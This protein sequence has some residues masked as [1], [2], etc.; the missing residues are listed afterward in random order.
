MSIDPK[1]VERWRRAKGRRE[2][3]RIYYDEIRPSL[4]G[5]LRRQLHL[6]RE[7]GE[8]GDYDTLVL[9]VGHDAVPGLILANA[10]RPRR[11]VVAYT[12]RNAGQ[13]QDLFLPGLDSMVREKVVIEFLE[14]GSN[15]HD[16]NYHKITSMLGDLAG[17][18]TVLCDVTGGKK[19]TSAHLGIAAERFGFD[20]SYID[21]TEYVENSA[22][23]EPG[24]EVLYIHSPGRRGVVEIE[25]WPGRNLQVNYSRKS[26][27][28][29]YTYSRGG[30][31]FK[32]EKGGFTGSLLEET[33]LGIETEYR[34]IDDAVM[35]SR[36]CAREL[37]ELATLLRTMMIPAGLDRM[38]RESPGESLGVIIDPELAGIPWEPVLVREYGAALP[39]TRVLN[40]DFDRFGLVKNDERHGILALL[41][42]GEGIEGYGGA[43][44]GLRDFLERAKIETRVV[45]ATDPGLV[46]RELG[47]RRY[48]AVVYFGHSVFYDDAASTGW[49]CANGEIFGC[50]NLDV[51]LHNPP[52]IVISSSCHSARSVPFARHSMAYHALMAGV[53]S[54]V[55]TRWFLEIERSTLFLSHL[56]RAMLVKGKPPRES[57]GTALAALEKKYGPD[58]SS[59][60]NYVYYG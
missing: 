13:V 31:Y 58:D 34:K 4:S 42:S 50:E 51:L 16:D 33:S 49:K 44:A 17:K 8:V 38:L 39:V 45:E 46:R 12:E 55:G 27:E 53:K 11:L 20:I 37:D 60:Y 6:K 59:L 47:R 10:L 23:P 2:K 54:Y 1:V 26:G 52:D 40:R 28:M 30:E 56:L 36:T 32:F 25:P 21:A 5:A 15:S 19:M 41:G 35:T 43:V 3:F 29:L 24:R 9:V 18:G 7:R 57:F 48:N 22:V 14:L